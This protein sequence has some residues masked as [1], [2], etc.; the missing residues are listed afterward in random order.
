MSKPGL[1]PFAEQDANEML[2]A[3]PVFSICEGLIAHF[4]GALEAELAFDPSIMVG[5]PARAIGQR[6][7]PG[8]FDDLLAG[9]SRMTVRLAPEFGSVPVE[10]TRLGV[11]EEGTVVELRSL[12]TEYQ[13]RELVSAEPS[14]WI[15]VERMGMTP[16]D[17]QPHPDKAVVEF[18]D[19]LLREGEFSSTCVAALFCSIDNRRSVE[20][21]LGMAAAEDLF[22]VVKERLRSSTRS[23]DVVGEF[24]DE[25]L[26]LSPGLPNPE[27]AWEF[28]QRMFAAASG[29]TLIAGQAIPVRVSVGWA[30]SSP[31]QLVTAE[32]L[33]RADLATRE[34]IRRGG[35]RAERF[36][37]EIG[38]NAVRT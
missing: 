4:S 16:P 3:I 31:G 9:T 21:A 10:L 29:Q 8:T 14:A 19:H 22:M 7:G 37:D 33:G 32:L 17:F 24:A 1:P 35:G 6:L 2:D 36:T 11:F 15:A 27:T 34:A 18:V 12:D 26:V 5:L 28:S 25:L 13:L 38:E 30:V 23:V 20:A